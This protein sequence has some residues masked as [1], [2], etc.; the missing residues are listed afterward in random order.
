MSH[1]TPGSNP[2]TPEHSLVNYLRGLTAM[3]A[4]QPITKTPA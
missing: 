3:L 1:G 2:F 4:D